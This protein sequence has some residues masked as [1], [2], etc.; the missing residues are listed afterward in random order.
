MIDFC[1]TD[2]AVVLDHDIDLVIQQ[3]DMLLDTKP[4]DVIG[5]PGYG[6]DYNRFLYETNIGASG[7]AA[8]IESHIRNT[9]D[10][11]SFDLQVQC[12]IHAGTEN[13]IILVYINIITPD[14]YYYRKVYNIS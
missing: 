2:D 12:T 9:I 10:L 1:I 6:C 13:D 4:R 8:Y 3:I 7:I 14:G 11:L 5:E